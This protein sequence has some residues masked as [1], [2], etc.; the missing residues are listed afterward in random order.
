MTMKIRAMLIRAKHRIARNTE[1]ISS[2]SFM[3]SILQILGSVS[4]GNRGDFPSQVAPLHL[5]D[6]VVAL[7]DV[8]LVRGLG[9][10]G[11]IPDLQDVRL[12]AVTRT[13][14]GD[15]G[16]VEVIVFHVIHYTGFG[17]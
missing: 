13:E 5:T 12:G 4:R 14:S 8:D 9:V 1:M 3:L 7:R 15:G 10:Q 16:A 6:V 17:G 11:L 2:V